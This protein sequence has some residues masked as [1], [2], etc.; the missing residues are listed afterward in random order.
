[1]AVLA[2]AQIDPAVADRGGR[3]RKS[4]RST[5]AA[6]LELAGDIIQADLPGIASL[7]RKLRRDIDIALPECSRGPNSSRPVPRKAQTDAVVEI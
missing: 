4:H 3:G 7:G 6:V 5:P 1:V 2:C